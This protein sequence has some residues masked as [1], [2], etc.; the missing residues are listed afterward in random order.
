MF[1]ATI[2][3][4]GLSE[5][6]SLVRDSAFKL[7]SI[8]RNISA[9]EL[10]SLAKRVQGCR[11]NFPQEIAFDLL[12]EICKNPLNIDRNLTSS[13]LCWIIKYCPEKYSY[14]L[15]L[16][17]YYD[18]IDQSP[19]NFA[20]DTIGS[21]DRN[22]LKFIE[23]CMTEKNL[24]V[25]EANIKEILDV[26]MDLFGIEPNTAFLALLHRRGYQLSS[27]FYLKYVDILLKKNSSSSFDG[28]YGYF[29]RIRAE[30]LHGEMLQKYLSI[31]EELMEC[32][33]EVSDLD[34]SFSIFKS[35]S[36]YNLLKRLQRPPSFCEYITDRCE[37]RT[38]N[39]PFKPTVNLECVRAAF[40]SVQSRSGY[41]HLL[42]EKFCS[43]A[44]HSALSQLDFKLADEIRA[45][46][47]NKGFVGA[48]YSSCQAILR[49]WCGKL[50]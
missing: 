41:W 8:F 27:I 28:L 2:K 45:F 7:R 36:K 37:R 1:L 43:V 12:R 50:K 40:T 29:R 31:G 32:F 9:S 19:L 49:H 3:C 20:L 5:T 48:D 23:R 44:F 42:D 24:K 25:E 39:W 34:H 21:N 33:L 6:E 22:S 13:L 4:H 10:I 14:E 26:A 30:N 16:G 46:M 18:F 15:L 17:E 47:N 35:I 11:K 38:F